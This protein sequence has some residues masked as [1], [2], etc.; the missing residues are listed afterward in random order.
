MVVEEGGGGPG[1]VK[2]W[3]G[4]ISNVPAEAGQVRGAI[5][6]L[7]SPVYIRDLPTAL[8]WSL[9]IDRPYASHLALYCL[10][11]SDGL[12]KAH[13]LLGLLAD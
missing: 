10:T 13:I 8:C 9:I 5:S 4:L 1:M 2:A 12:K 11:L 7:L 6:A 3:I